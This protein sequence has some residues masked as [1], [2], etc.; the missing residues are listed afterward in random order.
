[1]LEF[2]KNTIIK[3]LLIILALL[4]INSQAELYKGVDEEGNV[5]YSDKPFNNSKKYTPPA[6]TIVDA[7]KIPEKKKEVHPIMT[8]F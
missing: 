8:Y 1:M 6:I 2:M 5:I 7:P 4:S 3:S